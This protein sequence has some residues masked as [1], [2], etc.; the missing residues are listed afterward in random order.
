MI[1]LQPRHVERGI[2]EVEAW[3][4]SATTA[5][6]KDGKSAQR[7]LPCSL[8]HLAGRQAGHFGLE[9]VSFQIK[10]SGSGNEDL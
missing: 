10:A 5:N 8:S 2:S 9:S 6:E 7:V 4:G 1:L 3:R